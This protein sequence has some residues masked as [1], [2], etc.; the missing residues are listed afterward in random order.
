MNA[1]LRINDMN[2][3]PSPSGGNA[4]HVVISYLLR[5]IVMFI[6]ICSFFVKSKAIETGLCSYKI[7]YCLRKAVLQKKC[8]DNIVLHFGF[9]KTVIIICIFFKENG[10]E[11]TKNN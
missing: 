9:S 10:K 8:F 7:K 11:N 5:K 4:G 3:S 6:L 2:L 1:F